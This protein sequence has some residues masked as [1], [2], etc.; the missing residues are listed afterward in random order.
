MG[1]IHEG[2]IVRH[3]NA[4]ELGG[5]FEGLGIHSVFRE[6]IDTSNNVPAGAP[7]SF[8][9]ISVEVVVGVEGEASHAN[10]RSTLGVCSGTRPYRAQTFRPRLRPPRYRR[11]F[12]PGCR[13]NK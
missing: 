3:E 2:L 6:G 7:E 13:S 10:A 9:K 11:R 4:A 12:L 5:S 1:G 8:Y